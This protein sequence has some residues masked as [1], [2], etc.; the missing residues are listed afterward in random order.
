[1]K[2]KG[3]TLTLKKGSL[4]TSSPCWKKGS[5]RSWLPRPSDPA[6]C[7]ESSLSSE[8][9]CLRPLALASCFFSLKIACS[10]DSQAGTVHCAN[11]QRLQSAFKR[12]ACEERRHLGPAVLPGHRWMHTLLEALRPVSVT[13]LIQRHP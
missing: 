3:R 4:K 2:V 13:G 7:S 11:S 1:M 10:R 6:F 12:M 9:T 8:L 5:F